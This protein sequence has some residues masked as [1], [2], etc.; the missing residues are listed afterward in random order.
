M[1]KKNE[2]RLCVLTSE[3]D[4]IKRSTALSSVDLSLFI[5]LYSYSE[6]KGY[7]Y[8]E[9]NSIMSCAGGAKLARW[10]SVECRLTADDRRAGAVF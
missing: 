7:L 8:D 1:Y 5:R 4:Q 9:I 6:R 2:C 3:F 10:L